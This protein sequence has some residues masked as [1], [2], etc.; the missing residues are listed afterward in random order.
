MTSPSTDATPT[1]V[2]RDSDGT[3]YLLTEALLQTAR[4]T[5]EQQTALEQ[6]LLAQDVRGFNA[7][8][9]VSV[10]SLGG[11]GL[12]AAATISSPG[13]AIVFGQLLGQAPINQTGPFGTSKLGANVAPER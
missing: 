9:P 13:L 1:L 2:F 11:I 4:A 5:A 3:F 8:Q 7:G 6:A 12:I 10:V